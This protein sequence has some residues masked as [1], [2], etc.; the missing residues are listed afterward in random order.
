MRPWRGSAAGFPRSPSSSSRSATRAQT[1]WPRVTR[2][3]CSAAR[4]S[5]WCAALSSLGEDEAKEIA[6]YLKSPTPETC[7]ALFG[8]GGV[9]PKG[10]LAKAAEAA[11][12]VRFF[13][14]PDRKQA[15]DWVVKR[16]AREN[17]TCPVPVARRLVELV[18]DDMGELAPE[19]EKLI[20]FAHGTA[21]EIEDVEALVPPQVEIKPWEITDAWGRRD[22]SSM[23]ALAV[24]DIEAPGDV[25][26]VVSQLSAHVRKVWRAA[27][28]LE[29]G[30]TQADVAKELG[31]KP[32][33]TQKLVA[34]AQRFGASELGD[35]IVRLSALDMAVKGGSR[36]NARFELELALAE[37]ATE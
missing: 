12:E 8:A 37:I 17:V 33:P 19:V 25:N 29:R 23:I 2:S 28:M 35:A 1:W 26:R 5:C 13:D 6:A 34:Q 24:A 18:G 20:V 21:P 36:L 27:S 9:D 16:F 15:A 10:P 22:P 3:T 4:A 14:A 30:G 32:Y 31:M 7:L 11:G